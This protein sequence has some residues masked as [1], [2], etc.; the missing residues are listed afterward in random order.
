VRWSVFPRAAEQTGALHPQNVRRAGRRTAEL[1]RISVRTKGSD[2]GRQTILL[3]FD[4]QEI[5][6]TPWHVH[7]HTSR[8][9]NVKCSVCAQACRSEMIHNHSSERCTQSYLNSLLQQLLGFQ[10]FTNRQNTLMGKRLDCQAWRGAREL[11][12]HCGGFT[13]IPLSKGF[14]HR[15]RLHDGTPF[16]REAC[17]SHAPQTLIQQGF[18]CLHSQQPWPVGTVRPLQWNCP[19]DFNW[20][21]TWTLQRH[22]YSSVCGN[23]LHE[24]NCLS[25]HLQ[26][27]FYT[28]CYTQQA[29]SGRKPRKQTWIP[30]DGS[31][32]YKRRAL[33]YR[34]TVFPYALLIHRILIMDFYSA[35]KK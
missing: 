1:R 4:F 27:T 9:I 31:L 12:Q 35:K 21:S 6:G 11:Q 7:K 18:A 17:G 26:K 33:R 13:T 25:H 19:P 16:S 32:S 30:V 34:A 24:A 10:I 5:L 23:H 20:K 22:L 8:W 2:K 14:Q 3:R 29:T 28:K 15:V